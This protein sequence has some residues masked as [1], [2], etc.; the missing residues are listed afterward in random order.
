MSSTAPAASAAPPFRFSLNTSTIRGQKLPL[1]AEIDI[2]AEVGYHAVEP[3]ISEMETHVK[4]GGK[5]TEIRDRLRDKGLAVPSAIGFFEWI[6]DDPARRAKALEQARRDMDLVAQIGGTRIAA[7][8]WG[9]HDKAKMAGQPDVDLLQAAERYR[10]L[11]EIGREAGVVPQVEVWGFSHTLNRLGEAALVAIESG[12]PDACV[13]A[14]VYHL[15]KGGSPANGL[16]L[17]RGD[18]H[19]HVFHVNDYPADKPRA[20]ITDADR[21]YPGDGVAPLGEILRTL[22]AIGFSGY[23]SLEL[24]NATYYQQDARLVARTGLEK[25]RAAVEK[26]LAARVTA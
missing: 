24:F 13:L 3:W 10:A 20:T 11:L 22:R 16:S 8:P 23:L 7:P 4:S 2:A 19:L 15:Y 18:K 9:A 6:V 25:T 26:A 21:V 1:A 5:L 12:H 14:D 17:L